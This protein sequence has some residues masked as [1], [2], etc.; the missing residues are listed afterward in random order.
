[1]ETSV[2]MTIP[3]L[4]I[5][6]QPAARRIL[7][8]EVAKGVQQ[9][10]ERILAS[11]RLRVPVDQGNLRRF[12]AIRPSAKSSSGAVLVQSVIAPGKQTPYAAGVEEGTRPHWIT[13]EDFENLQGWAKRKLGDAKFA[14]AVRHNI[15]K[16]GTKAQ[17]FLEPASRE[18]EPQ[19]DIILAGSVA[20]AIHR[21][22]Q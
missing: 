5:F 19:V 15:A 1:M 16:R 8:E 20:V 17:P 2:T 7:Q 22:Q 11:A 9:I 21:M 12:L 6:N 14:Y 3:K 18:V 13:G 4:A 10:E